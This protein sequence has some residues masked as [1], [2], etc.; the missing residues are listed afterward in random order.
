MPY[1]GGTYICVPLRISK[2]V[3]PSNKK[4][5]NE[6]GTSPGGLPLQW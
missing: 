1:S 6:T 3:H 5:D 2:A 4:K